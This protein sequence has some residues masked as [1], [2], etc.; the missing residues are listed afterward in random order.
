MSKTPLYFKRSVRSKFLYF[1]FL[2]KCFLVLVASYT[3]VDNRIN[4]VFVMKE[5]RTSVLTSILYFQLIFR[6][7]EEKTAISGRLGRSCLWR[8]LVSCFE[9]VRTFLVRLKHLFLLQIVTVATPICQSLLAL[10]KHDYVLV[11]GDK[12]GRQ[13]P[14]RF[15]YNKICTR[16]FYTV[17]NPVYGCDY[18]RCTG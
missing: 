2:E 10:I 5:T 8:Y 7:I 13:S 16:G 3:G 11:H 18:L 15:S 1:P 6:F 4:P 12:Y 14:M 9:F 17:N